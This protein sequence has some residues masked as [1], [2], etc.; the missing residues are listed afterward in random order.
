MGRAKMDPQRVVL[1]PEGD[2]GLSYTL[3]TAEEDKI[4]VSLK[5]DTANLGQ[6]VVPLSAKH[7]ALLVSVGQQLMALPEE[8]VKKLRQELLQAEQ[9]DNDDH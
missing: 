7:F 4:A 6:F 8:K 3:Q 5:V 9:E 1:E 2:S